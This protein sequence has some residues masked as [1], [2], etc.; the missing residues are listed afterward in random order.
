MRKV[1]AFAFTVLALLSVTWPATSAFAQRSLSK[2]IVGTWKMV[3]W[4]T[5][6]QNGEVLNIF[7][8][9]NPTGVIMYQ[10][11]GYMAIQVMANPRSRFAQNPVTTSP[12]SPEFR[13]AFFG[14]YAYF[15]TYKIDDATSTVYHTVLAS[16]RTVEVGLVYHR[17][18]SIEGT[19]LV[20]TTPSYT[21]GTN[22][23]EEVLES[24]Q[25]SPSEQLTNRLTFERV[26]LCESTSTET[27][28]F[29]NQF[30]CRCNSEDPH[31]SDDETPGSQH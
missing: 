15:G 10:P 29:D 3:S 13:N 20:L 4:E 1:S 30:P 7:A 31:D 2:K 17:S 27:K 12:S 5:I 23:T 9:Q 28:C 19:K 18:V 8:G 14:Y 24:A 25:I 21:A 6:R 22:F 26:D 16:E 11:N